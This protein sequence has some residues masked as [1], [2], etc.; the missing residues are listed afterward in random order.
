MDDFTAIQ[1]AEGIQDYETTEELYSA[2]QHL[3]DTGICWNL[4]GWFGRNAVGFLVNGYVEATTPTA[5]ALLK[6]EIESLDLT[7]EEWKK[8]VAKIIKKKTKVF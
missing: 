2:W 8:K 5:K 7:E 3:I 6:R 1:I 4:Q